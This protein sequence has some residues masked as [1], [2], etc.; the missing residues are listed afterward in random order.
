MNEMTRFYSVLSLLS[1]SADQLEQRPR[2]QCDNYQ[3]QGDG[4]MV[5]TRGARLTRRKSP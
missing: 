4:N 5:H 3:I 1:G 2:H